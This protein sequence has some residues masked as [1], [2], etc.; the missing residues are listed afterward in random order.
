MANGV[1]QTFLTP[2]EIA[3]EMRVDYRAF[4]KK[5]KRGEGPKFKRYGTRIKIRHDWYDAWLEKDDKKCSV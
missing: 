5:L 1:A 3:D 4:L 2:K